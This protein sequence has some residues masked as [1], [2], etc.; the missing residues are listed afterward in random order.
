MYKS[1]QTVARMSEAICGV[2]P[3]KADPGCRLRSSGLHRSICFD[4]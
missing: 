1:A 2:C 3:V 4:A